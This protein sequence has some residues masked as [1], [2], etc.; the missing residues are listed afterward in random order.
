MSNLLLVSRIGAVI[1]MGAI[2]SPAAASDA[3]GGMNLLVQLVWGTDG[4]KPEGKSLKDV[5]QAIRDKLRGVFRW[6][7]YFEV[8]RR[9]FPVA[10]GSVSKVRISP[11][12]EIEV[13]N[14]GKSKI[15]VNLY[16]ENRKVVTKRQ[17]LKPVELL[18]LAGD[19]EDN[20]AWFVVIRRQEP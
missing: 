12:C 18:V 5:D 8:E 14:L 7:N 10:A 11:K 4:P 13:L 16:G 15:E 19:D 2:I 1:L 20:T 3:E 9:E 17:V 6:K